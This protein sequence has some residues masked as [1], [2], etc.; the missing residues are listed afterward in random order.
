V[1][2]NVDAPAQLA[3]YATEN[4]LD[5]STYHA[6]LESLTKLG[7]FIDVEPPFADDVLIRLRTGMSM[8]NAVDEA[9]T[10]ALAALD[11]PS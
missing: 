8:S 7:R 2:N 11:A 4:D 9:R 10:I 1:V 5:L 3:A 6:V